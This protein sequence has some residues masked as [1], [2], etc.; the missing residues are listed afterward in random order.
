MI[1][2][3]KARIPDG[4]EQA[5]AEVLRSGYVGGA[6]KCVAEFERRL[7]EVLGV[8]DPACVVTTNSGTSAIFLALYLMRAP[9]WRVVTTPMTFVAT[10]TAIYQ[11]GMRPL[12]AD[13][14]PWS[15]QADAARVAQ[16]LDESKQVA[17]AI[18]VAWGGFLPDLR[19][20]QAACV[21][22]GVPL[23]IDAAQAFGARLAGRPLHEFAD[24]VAYSFAPV[25]LLTTGDGGALVCRNRCQ[26]DHARRLAWFGMR[27]DVRPPERWPSDQNIGE[28]GFKMHMN[29]LTAAL[30]L[31]GLDGVDEALARCRRN[32]EAYQCTFS[33]RLR[34]EVVLADSDPSPYTYTVFVRDVP[35]FV[36]Y[37]EARGVVVGQPHRRNDANDFAADERRMLPQ[38]DTVQRHYCSIPV[39]WWLT[40]RDLYHIVQAVLD[41]PGLVR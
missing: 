6:G 25:K 21:A 13:V 22:H 28:W 37:M 34:H 35:D 26:A 2:L 30:G 38:T 11:A 4:A 5:V 32:V 16:R 10:T 9:G 15:C 39:G 29:N 8:S 33:H 24:Y 17:A 1:P 19:S 14:V 41:Y 23:L 18:A 36:S 31:A 7:A 40:E 12:W 27:R 20:I 3:L